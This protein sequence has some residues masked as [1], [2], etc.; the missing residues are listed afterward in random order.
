MALPGQPLNTLLQPGLRQAFYD[1]LKYQPT[2]PFR[3]TR[4][5]KMWKDVNGV[6]L[7]LQRRRYYK[8]GTD[9]DGEPSY[10]CIGTLSEGSDYIA[11]HLKP[12]GTV[13]R[14]NEVEAVNV[15]HPFV[16]PSICISRETYQGMQMIQPVDARAKELISR[17]EKEYDRDYINLYFND[18][19]ALSTF[20]E[21]FPW[22]VET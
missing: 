7:S 1:W 4:D 21:E 16:E 2:P 9:I 18:S 5:D 6:Q 11:V 13:R 12:D 20:V 22:V 15:E 8:L 19:K 17:V 14:L 10:I 3:I